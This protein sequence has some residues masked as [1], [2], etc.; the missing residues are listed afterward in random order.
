MDLAQILHGRPAAVVA[1][2]VE[3]HH[4]PA[5]RRQQRQTIVQLLLQ[6]LT[7]AV[8]QRQAVRRD[9]ASVRRA[10]RK[11]ILRQLHFLLAGPH[12][13]IRVHPGFFQQLRQ[14]GVVAEAVDAVAHA[15]LHAEFLAEIRLRQQRLPRK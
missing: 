8:V 13:D 12:E 2:A 15:G 11:Q 9:L 3:E 10:P 5:L 4:A 1:D 14:H 7:E 6:L